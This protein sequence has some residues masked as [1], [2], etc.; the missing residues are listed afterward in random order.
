MDKYYASA[1]VAGLEN[2]GISVSQL[3]KLAKALLE[4][5][6]PVFWVRGEISGLKMYSH[7]YFDLKDESYECGYSKNRF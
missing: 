6:M 4:N 2:E 5:N 1:P 7:A 3:N